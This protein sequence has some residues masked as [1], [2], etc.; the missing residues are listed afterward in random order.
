MGARKKKSGVVVDESRVVCS[1][2]DEVEGLD[3]R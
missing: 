2:G 1:I 3:W